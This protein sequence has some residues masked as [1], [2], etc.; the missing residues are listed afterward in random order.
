MSDHARHLA[1]VDPSTGEIVSSCPDCRRKDDEIAGLEKV[2]RSQGA[3][4][5]QLQRDKL[6]EAEAH[7]WWPQA[8]AWRKYWQRVCN[9]PNVDWSADSR[10]DWFWDALPFLKSRLYG[11]WIKAAIDG[12][13]FDPATKRYRN[14]TAQR[15]DDWS[16]I[17]RGR[18]KFASFVHRAPH[19]RRGE[20]PPEL[21][22]LGK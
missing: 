16:L 13:A 15:F 17:F 8:V 7:P 9:H 18:D 14:G 20:L 3:Q 21:E 19:P 12:A 4:I 1:L 11:E 10:A 5:R 22:G 2:I 6:R